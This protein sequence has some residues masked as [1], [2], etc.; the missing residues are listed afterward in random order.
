MEGSGR[1]PRARRARAFWAKGDVLG[2]RPG[3]VSPG[4][5]SEWSARPYYTGQ[6]RGREST[7]RTHLVDCSGTSGDTDLLVWFS[8]HQKRLMSGFRIA[9]F[10]W[11]ARKVGHVRSRRRSSTVG[12]PRGYSIG[13]VAV[14]GYSSE[15]IGIA[16]IGGIVGNGRVH[17]ADQVSVCELYLYPHR[18]TWDSW[19]KGATGD[20]E[21]KRG[22]SSCLR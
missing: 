12:S 4:G 8:D 9:R 17:A 20:R 15:S 2:F 7:A 14:S 19:R 6:C 10:L 16:M 13:V 18:L 3:R 5:P 11:P 1:T 22:P 21:R